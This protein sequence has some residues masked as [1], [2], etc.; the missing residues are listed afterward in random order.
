MHIYLKSWLIEVIIYIRSSPQS[1]K[2]KA[3]VSDMKQSEIVPIEV[4][5]DFNKC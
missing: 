4:N 5:V 3:F 1:D 2:F